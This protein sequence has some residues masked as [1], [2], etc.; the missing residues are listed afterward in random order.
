MGEAPASEKNIREVPIDEDLKE[1]YLTYAMSVIVSR[2]LP[3][4]RDGLK[5]SQRRVLVAMNQLNLGPRAARVKCALIC[6]TTSGNYH[7]HGEQVVYPTLVRMAQD[8]NL[9]YTLVDPQGNF[10]SIDGFPAAAM[11]YTEARMSP[12]AV[13]MLDDIQRDTVDMVP[14]YDGRLTEPTVLPGRL[15][16]LL[17]NGASGIAV[18]MATSIPPHNLGEVADAVVAL[19]DDPE[20]TVGG[21]MKHIPAPDFP[22]GGIICGRAGIRSAYRT[23]HGKL[24]V[25]SRVH[26]ETAD[27]GK[28]TIVITEIPYQLTKETLVKRIAQ[29]ARDKTVRGI[30][31]LQDHSDREGMRIAIE[32]ARGEDENVVLNQLYQ[33]TP[34]QSTFSIQ[35]I[36]LV[37]GRPRTLGLKDML[38][39]FRDHRVEVIRRR[40]EY[41]LR[42]ARERSHILEGLLVALENIDAVIETIRASKDVPAAR[43]A[44]QRK[45]G[46]SERQATAI[47]EMRLQRLT[48]LE[49]D[50]VQSEY[51]ELREKIRGYVAILADETAVLDII[52]EDVFE[53]KEKYGDPRRTEVTGSVEDFSIEDL[54]AEEQMA[55]SI[56][57]AGYIK[58]Q[59]LSSYRSQ[60][61]GGKGIMGMRVKEEDVIESLFVA[62][63]LDYILFFTDKGKVHWLKVYDIPQLGRASKGRA[64]VNVLSL[65]PEEHVTATIPVREFDDE[66]FVV[67]ATARGVIKRSALSAFGNPRRGG[68]IAANLKKDDRLVGCTVTDGTYELLLATRNGMAARFGEGDVR[69]MGRTAAGVRGIRLK[70]GDEVVALVR[71]EAGLK[72]LTV[73]QNGYGKRSAIEDYRLIKRGGQGVININTSERNG[74]VVSCMAVADD[75]EV[76]AITGGGQVVRMPVRQIRVT[77]RAAQ[78]VRVVSF[79]GEQDTLASLAKVPR[80]ETEPPGAEAAPDD[81]DAD[82]GD[83]DDENAAAEAAEAGEAEPPDE[84]VEEEE[85]GDEGDGEVEEEDDEE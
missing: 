38:E 69:A 76:M 59:P 19:I 16:N 24:I 15:P 57:H 20:I 32:L 45:F 53:L 47:L 8:F 67:M 84:E 18:G 12:L 81:E 72:V 74:P 78:G 85:E 25:R 54:I 65:G 43:E 60:H 10:G 66:H 83:A 58:R 37:G 80:E 17:V 30:S 61:R 48:G 23:G 62:S 39:C 79:K 28:K 9:R 3:D 11:R 26:V 31:D 55:V 36:A 27:S 21:L 4:V 7:P 49:R 46:L 42:L 75:D 34:M 14:N 29:A 82:N 51:D 40:T 5:P 63:T 52:R 73:C 71:L 64:V 77:G 70:K 6:G 68:I 13:E 41:L 50:A 33:R 1:S 22:T 44:L 2:A 35:M 56:T